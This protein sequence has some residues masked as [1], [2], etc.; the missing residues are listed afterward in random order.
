MRGDWVSDSLSVN[1]PE[2]VVLG[3]HGGRQFKHVFE[4]AQRELRGKFGME[5][6]EL[7]VKEKVTISQRRGMSTF[8]F[9][10][11]GGATSFMSTY[12]DTHSPCSIQPPNA[13]KNKPQPRRPGS[14]RPP[15]RQNTTPTPPSSPPLS[16]PAQAQSLPTSHSTLSSTPYSLFLQVA[17]SPKPSLPATFIA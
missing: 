9:S 3:A 1:M 11:L 6:T 7:P 8:L 16:S 14:S 2:V 5:M 12:A 17:P 10:L 15:Y 4:D 13:Q